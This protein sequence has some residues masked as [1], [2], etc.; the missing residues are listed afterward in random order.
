MVVLVPSAEHRDDPQH[1]K[2]GSPDQ[3]GEIQSHW[4]ST[5]RLHPLC[6]G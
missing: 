1:F 2:F 6:V 3:Y 4:N 5:G